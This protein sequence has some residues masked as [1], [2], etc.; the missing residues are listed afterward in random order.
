MRK[1]P[2]KGTVTIDKDDI[3][4]KH[5]NKLQIISYAYQCWDNTKGGEK[6][7][8]YYNCQCECGV[9]KTI[10]R[11]LLTSELVHSCGCARRNKSGRD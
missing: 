8:H 5:L 9:L 6:S 3:I 1:G 10:Q 7:R 2:K 11:G 4:G